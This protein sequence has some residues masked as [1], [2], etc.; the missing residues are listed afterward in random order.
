MKKP[1]G[2][3]LALALAALLLFLSLN[4]ARAD[5][6]L[7]PGFGNSGK[8]T[9]NF[10]VTS[11]I[12]AI[13]IQP[14][15]KI[16]AAGSATNSSG[17]TGFALARYNAGGSLDTM[18]GSAG[19]VTTDFFGRNDLARGVAIQPDGKI[20]V[21]GRALTGTDGFDFALARYNADGNLDADF[22]AGGKITADFSG[23]SSGAEGVAIQ[24]DGKIIVAGYAQTGSADGTRSFALARYNAD[25]TLDASFGSGGKATTAFFNDYDAALA[26]AIQ[27]D[28]KMVLAGITINRDQGR[29]EYALARYNTDGSLDRSF[30]SSGKLTSYLSGNDGEPQGMKI[31]S[32]GKIVVAGWTKNP[33]PLHDFALVRYSIDGRLDASF[34]SGGLVVTD[35]SG[36]SD[37]A[38]D[39]AFQEDGKIVVGGWKADIGLPTDFALARYNADGSL[40]SSFGLGGKI[41]Y[42]FF[43]N[44][45]QITSLAIQPDG[46]IIAAG[47]AQKSPGIPEF[48]LI[49]FD[50][51]LQGPP[52]PAPAF[53]LRF[54]SPEVS[55]ERG[56]SVVLPI[57]I[58]RTGGHAS[59]VTIT[60][61]DTAALK[62]KVKPPDP[63][64]TT[65]TSAKFKL[66][67]KAGAPVGSYQITFTGSDDSGRVSTATLTLVIQ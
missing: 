38:L 3:F 53:T 34:G 66:K 32:D 49:R 4:L 39:L 35:F 30:G 26:I 64:S 63:V 60:P 24:N 54:D 41:T 18:F 55:A 51:S 61:P 50:P 7:D 57:N 22:G 6:D 1:T 31:Q 10:F 36:G 58:V 13:A 48:A 46:R 8:V 59:T 42:D 47:S 20:V 11:Q 37:V 28:G 33:Y 25:G 27:A 65:G 40:D 16:V 29:E 15:G 56:T 14:D 44:Y 43:G 19:K 52:P 9:T 12:S 45:D 21:A 5:G 23:K 2:K 62:I 67:I 17:N